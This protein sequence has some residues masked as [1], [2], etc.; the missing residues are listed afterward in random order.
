[1]LPPSGREDRLARGSIGCPPPHVVKSRNE[2][3]LLKGISKDDRT[4]ALDCRSYLGLLLAMSMALGSI[5]CRHASSPDASLLQIREEVR[6][7]QLDVALREVDA[8]YAKY[9]TNG[10]WGARLLVQ[11]AHILVLRGSYSEALQLL[12]D[13]LPASLQSSDTEV[14]R[15]MLVG[16]AHSYL[17]EF[18]LS[19]Q[20]LSEAESMAAAIHSSFFGDVAQVR[21]ILEM[22]RRNYAKATEAYR[23]AA[24]FAREHNLP[25]AELNALASLGNVAMWQEHYDEAVDRFK[26]ALEKSRSVGAASIEAKTL[27][28]L[29][30]SYLVVGDFENAE[31]FLTEAESKSA[32]AGLM[33]DRTYWLNSLA[34]VYAQQ[35]RYAEAEATGQKALSLARETDD[36]RTLTECLN[37]LSEM[38]LATG[39]VDIAEKHNREALEIERAG[40]DQFGTASSTI[41]AGRIAASKEQFREAGKTFQEVIRNK[42]VETPLRWESEA[43]L[44]QVYAEDNLPTDAE[45]EFRRAINSIETARAGVH[46]DEFRLSFLSAAIEFYDDYV[47]F[48]I[49]RKRAADALGVAE[50]SRARTL[51]EGL[52]TEGDSAGPTFRAFQ[53][54][55][56]AKRLKATLLFYWIGHNQSYLW[57]IVP[58]KTEQFRLAKAENIEPLVKAYQKAVLGMRDAEDPGGVD[59][60]TLYGMLVEPAKKLIQPGSRVIILP[61]ES[62]YGLNFET[63]IVPDPKPHFWIEDVTL[64]TA[65]SLTLLEH[66][67]TRPVTRGKSLLLVGDTLRANADFPELT[68]APAEMQK[69][70]HYFPESQREV[71]EGKQA[72]PSAY[73]SSNPERFA[74]LHFVTHGTASHTRPL[75]SAV[76][77]SKEGDSYKL[78]ARDIVQHHLNA[79]LVTISACNGSGTRAYS[80]EGLVGL[81]WAFLRAGAHNVIGALW[82]VSDASTPQL[83]DALYSELSQGKDPAKALRDAKLSLLHSNDPR[84]VFKKPFYWAPFQ[85]YAGS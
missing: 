7:G 42:K 44:A 3:F 84:S 17:Q 16:L 20:A 54:Q 73:L 8:A 57:V 40:L 55:E 4:L 1:M 52:A 67:T 59:G 77:L 47:D 11:K 43:R 41:I 29:G 34:G 2:R 6:R 23:T 28:N 32:Q 63:L 30:W 12:N 79:D 62:L 37:T 72:T 25:R 61:S 66:S 10:E 64:T 81:S 19:D 26:A 35:H 14:Q 82:E 65:S 9:R 58:A 21:G 38:E 5:G 53:P 74:Y 71:L 60:K 22:N 80:G 18:E 45:A 76:I 46:R 50:L 85:L 33:N 51:E 15:K 48:L 31:T 49:R 39:N 24:T 13:S 56:L 83:M 68:Q 27:G 70:E 69:I 78:Y 36:K 75:E